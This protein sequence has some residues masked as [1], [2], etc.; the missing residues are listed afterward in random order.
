MRSR[1]ILA[2]ICTLFAILVCAPDIFAGHILNRSV[3]V[4]RHRVGPLLGVRHV[5]KS[6]SR[7]VCAGCHCG[8]LCGNAGCS[9]AGK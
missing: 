6:V 3:S 1:S 7:S 8:G 4:T 9:C 2:V 5:T